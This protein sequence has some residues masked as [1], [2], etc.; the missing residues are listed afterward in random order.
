MDPQPMQKA[1]D[2]LPVDARQAVLAGDGTELVG[3]WTLDG[4]NLRQ[5]K[6]I[7]PDGEEATKANGEPYTDEDL[8]AIV[9]PLEKN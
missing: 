4:S 8:T 6:L 3:F 1:L 9:V 7:G 2:N 5:F